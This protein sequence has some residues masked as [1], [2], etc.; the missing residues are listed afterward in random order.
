MPSLESSTHYQNDQTT[1]CPSTDCVTY[2]SKFYLFLGSFSIRRLEHVPVTQ[3]SKNL[4]IKNLEHSPPV[5][6][7][8]PIL[9]ILLLQPFGSPKETRFFPNQL[10]PSKMTWTRETRKCQ[11]PNTATGFDVFLEGNDGDLLMEEIPKT[12]WDLKKTL[13]K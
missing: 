12:A 13:S 11:W 10:G 3:S 1:N 6:T 8:Y 4:S 9:G 7:T 5:T 2:V